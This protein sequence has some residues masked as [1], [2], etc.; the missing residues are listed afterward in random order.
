M[1]F[2]RRRIYV[3]IGWAICSLHIDPE[4]HSLVIHLDSES[5][6]NSYVSM[7]LAIFDHQVLGLC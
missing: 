6:D 1:L 4:T 2:G 7:R 3:W 5:I